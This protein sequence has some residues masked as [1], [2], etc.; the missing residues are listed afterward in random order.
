MSDSAALRVELTLLQQTIERLDL[1]LDG[2]RSAMATRAV[3]DQAKGA[4]RVTTGAS[5]D[6][7][8]QLLA[9]RSQHH[10]RKLFDV[11]TDIL[12][13]V[14][15][16]DRTATLLGLLAPSRSHRAG[17]RTP[18]PAAPESWR[19][20]RR[21]DPLTLTIS[22][23]D[24]L[25][26]LADLGENLAAAGD[27]P[28]VVDV[29]LQVGAD[30]MGAFGAGIAVLT[31]TG[32]A[33]VQVSGLQLVDVAPRSLSLDDAH[34]STDVLRSG[35][36][37]LLSRA[38]LALRYAEHP[39]PERLGGLAVLPIAGSTATPAAWSLYLDRPMPVDRGTR[40]FLDRAA[41]LA[42]AAFVRAARSQVS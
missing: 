21:W 5:D 1:E 15:A 3:I 29:L 20:R 28:A 12:A 27:L 39:R 31:G 42:S 24:Q 8:F 35:R 33:G 7:A 9:T 26:V 13:A 14:D 22:D 25:R 41:R 17:T 38:D 30:A 23:V 32:T 18:H 6:E 34:P 16:P 37:L 11:A 36:R 19:T 2:L 40:A 4:L 10:N